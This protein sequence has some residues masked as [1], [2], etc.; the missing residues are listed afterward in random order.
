MKTTLFF[1]FFLFGYHSED[2]KIDRN[3]SCHVADITFTE[4]AKTIYDQTGTRI[5]YNEES[6][7]NIKVTLDADSMNVV[8]AV[9]I[10]LKNSG[11]EASVWHNS[12]V[13]IQGGKLISELPLFEN[14]EK[15]ADTTTQF[16]KKI[17][18]SETKYI[19]GRKT[20]IVKTIRVGSYGGITN[21]KVKVLGR[22]TQQDSG[23]PII[24]ATIYIEET[25]AG[26]VTDKNGFFSLV[27]TPNSYNAKIECLGF[28]KSKYRLEVLSNG[29]FSVELKK[30]A[31][32][33]DEI[34]VRGNSQ[35]N[36]KSR[37]P[38][39]EKIS[40]KTIKEI[41]M[42]IGERD[43]L[44]VSSLLP[45]IISIGEGSAG[46]NV[47]GGGSDQNAFYINKIPIYNTS[48]LF[49]FFPAF[50]SDIIKDFSIYKGHVP[51]QYG[52]KLSS[53]FNI[54]AREGNKKQFTVH[55][56]VNPVSAN[57]TLEGPII[58]DTLTVLLNAR[59][60]YSD[61]ILSRIKDPTIRSS[62]A[63]FNDFSASLNYDLQKAQ[64]SLFIYNSNDNFHLADINNYKYSNSGASLD[65]RY[66]FNNSIKADFALV[67]AKYSFNTI[68]QQEPSTA[69][70]HSYKLEHYELKC[71]FNH[72]INEKTTFDYGT[73]FILYKLFRGDV[74]PYG[75][76]SVRRPLKL[77]DERGIE[78]AMYFN[79]NYNILPWLNLTL[80]LRYSLFTPIGPRKVYTY[81][82]GYPRNQN[83]ISDSILFGKNKP[84]KWYSTPEFR[85]AVNIETDPLGSIKLAYNKMQQNLFMLNNA[86]SIAP[87]TQWKL[88]DYYLKPSK[89]NQVSIGVYRNLPKG[90]WETSVEFY[91]KNT[92]NF[93]EFKD[94]ANFLDNPNVETTVLQ[95]NQKAYGVEFFIK[96][97][98]HKLDGWLSYTYSRSIVKI[99]G[100]NSWDKI[101]DGDSY[102]A[103]YDVP[104][105]LSALINYHF[106]RRVI[107]S[108]IICYQSGRPI[109]YPQSVFYLNGVPYYDYSK[110]NKYN[111][112]DYF[113]VDASLTFEGNLKKR[114][115]LH[116]SLMFNVY[117][118]T[119]RKN[120]YSVY[121]KTEDGKIRSYKY[122]IIG[123]PIFTITWIFKLGNY[124][125]D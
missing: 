8:S 63:A 16:T 48:H 80:G 56:G 108:T 37:D 81:A 50:N 102:P 105:S 52:G 25:G 35:F 5:Y 98:N 31:I 29:E 13:I 120:P 104:N 33:I 76:S 53:V 96:R 67:G 30:T 3:I 100:K 32:L 12:I 57:I 121:F 44:K 110:R 24:G 99:D 118:L 4:F 55:G 87:N 111:I 14:E 2:T 89:S 10:A 119:G 60:S 123:V 83:F 26:S 15:R 41:P 1:L 90:G 27:M 40:T 66:I 42:M 74:N 125:S 49:G 36:I 64:T 88:A 117:N 112:P 68:D 22:I 124:A 9:K 75:E 19:T 114:K 115:L 59:S 69:L 43:I 103:N 73:D 58:K 72:T 7:K 91:Y 93:P 95:G 107:A 116:S 113:R 70:Q 34:V 38:G 109:T 92:S 47:R 51:P 122:S 39:L 18:A 62:S 71:D 84:I 11:L 82:S 45:G 23:E 79:N 54:I 101:N 65:Y 77:G 86:T 106:S 17:T 20:D 21:S 6:V 97:S 46:L 28:E 94:G 85:I 61:W 78:S